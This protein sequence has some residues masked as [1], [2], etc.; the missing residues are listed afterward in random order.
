MKKGTIFANLWAGHETY[1][2]YQGAVGGRKRGPDLSWGYKL[3][4]FENKWHLKKA[5]FYTQDLRDAEHFPVVG[6]IDIDA[7]LKQSILEAIFSKDNPQ[8]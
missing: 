3:V 4:F 6:H 2:V 8:A 5:S 1:F 7:L